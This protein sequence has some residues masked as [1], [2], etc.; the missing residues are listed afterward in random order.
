MFAR[1][2][3]LNWKTDKNKIHILFTKREYS[4]PCLLIAFSGLFLLLEIAR[5]LQ[6][7]FK[8]RLMLG[9]NEILRNIQAECRKFVSY[10]KYMESMQ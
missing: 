8:K 2:F 5:I 6:E 7:A 4:T 1:K 9:L 10:K 3:L